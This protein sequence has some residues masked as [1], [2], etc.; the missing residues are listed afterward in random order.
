MEAE[1]AQL[2]NEK[3]G[4]TGAQV[5]LIVLLTLLLAAGGTYWLVRTYVFPKEFKPVALSA[6]EEQVLEDKLRRLEGVSPAPRQAD[7]SQKD[8]DA[9]WLRPEAYSEAGASRRI[10]FSERELNGLIARDPQWSDKV[11]IDLADGLASARALIN[12]DP[13]F[14]LIGGRT[15]RVNAGVELNYA[16]GRPVVILKGVS[17]MGVPIP[18]DWMGN[19]KN[20][21]LV[22]QFGGSGGFWQAFAAGVESLSLED[23]QLVV[24]LRE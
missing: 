16:N 17:V 3:N 4:F 10:E 14:P 7:S 11:A 2:P 1:A 5:A 20:V 21:D 12:V 15:L 23:G 6:R 19:L 24:Q 9:A 18:N 13:D 8:D 22:S